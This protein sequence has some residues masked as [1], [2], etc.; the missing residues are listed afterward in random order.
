MTTMQFNF[1]YCHCLLVNPFFHSFCYKF[2][3]YYCFRTNKVIT[4]M[5]VII[6]RCILPY[7]L[8]LLLLLV[9]LNNWLVKTLNFNKDDDGSI[10]FISIVTFVDADWLL[11]MK[12]NKERWKN[13]RKQEERGPLW[14]SMGL[15]FDGFFSLVF[16]T[17]IPRSKLY[18]GSTPKR[19]YVKIKPK[20]RK[21][22]KWTF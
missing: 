15:F 13:K 19:V 14:W 16:Y 21:I 7:F 22:V 9:T 3:C 20:N 8:L 18:L 4:T 10:A 5:M 17:Q 11:S 12:R 2:S 6:M 1:S